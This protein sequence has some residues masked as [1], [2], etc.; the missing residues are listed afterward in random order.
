MLAI[1]AAAAAAAA[2]CEEDCREDFGVDPRDEVPERRRFTFRC[3]TFMTSELGRARGGP[4]KADEVRGVAWIPFCVSVPN[5]DKGRGY[6]YPKI[7]RIDPR[8]QNKRM[9]FF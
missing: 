7:A 2:D 4:S 8:G 9:T 1:W 6:N 5:A 3:N